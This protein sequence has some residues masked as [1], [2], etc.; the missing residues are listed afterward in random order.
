[1]SQ[2]I[3]GARDARTRKFDPQV[4][5]QTPSPQHGSHGNEKSRPRCSLGHAVNG[6]GGNSAQNAACREHR[7]ATPRGRT[8]ASTPVGC[9]DYFVIPI[10][11]SRVPANSGQMRTLG[12]PA[13]RPS[14]WTARIPHL[15]AGGGH[16]AR[17]DKRCYGG[18]VMSAMSEFSRIRSNTIRLPSGDTS[19]RWS[20]SPGARAVNRRR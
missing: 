9:Q 5:S 16:P 1:M 4:T 6:R 20:D 13:D 17:N 12:I 8:L 14:T 19:N 3:A 15:P 7:D 11:R 10:E 18:S 2:R